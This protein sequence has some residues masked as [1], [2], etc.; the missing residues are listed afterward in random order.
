MSNNDGGHRCNQGVTLATRP[1]RNTATARLPPSSGQGPMAML[2]SHAPHGM[3]VW[4]IQRPRFVPHLFNLRS[5]TWLLFAVLGCGMSAVHAA[6][7]A[8]S[9]WWPVQRPPRVLIPTT[10]LET[11]GSG[12]A[13]DTSLPSGGLSAEHMLVQSAAGL[14]ARAVNESRSDEM[15]WI[16]VAS[17]SYE[18]WKEEL[19]ERLAL[20][21]E[22]PH[23]PWQVVERL[24][25]QGIVKG[26]VV[27]S[28]D[29]SQGQPYTERAEVDQSA[30]VATVMAGLQ[31]AVLVESRM[32]PQARQLGLKKLGDA[33]GKSLEWCF[34]TY[35]DRLYRR[36]LF[37]LDP[38]TAHNRALAVAH[39]GMVIYGVGDLLNEVL[40]WLEPPSAVAGWN[41]GNEDQHTLPVSRYGHFQ[42]ASNWALNLP[43]LSAA[44]ET[45]MPR[46]LASA[47]L[48]PTG[49]KRDG[50]AEHM[51]AFLMSDGDNL[52]WSLGNFAHSAH[53][54]QHP[55]R[56]RVPVGWTACPGHLRQMCPGVLDYLS[57]TQPAHT[58]FIEYGGGY[59]Y[60][61]VFASK[62]DNRLELLAR[63]AGRIG[64]HMEATGV[65]LLSF[66]CQDVDS[67]A[68]HDA[69][70]V[71]A[72]EIR[73]LAGMFA[74]Q[75]YPYDGGDGKIF[76]VGNPKGEAIPVVTPKYTVWQDAH[77]P[78]GGDPAKIAQLIN[79]QAAAASPDEPL[80]V[81]VAVNIWSRFPPHSQA[82]RSQDLVG[83]GSVEHCL[84][85]LDPSIRVVTPEALVH[86]L[87]RDRTTTRPA[88]PAADR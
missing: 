80:R 3:N 87:R 15:V 73:N 17:P 16:S 27:Y 48:E 52:Q 13:A 62:R 39:R 57:R 14:A 21:T 45:A 1:R 69:Y 33:R 64:I 32:E 50:T 29:E 77:W 31:D 84:G 86:Q 24:A 71:Y 25:R 2:K 28:L 75:Y 23:R 26:Y 85:S 51:V 74:L 11:F 9:R 88:L 8:A 54:W 20:D 44:A 37:T 35:R 70:Q 65:S 58:S 68:A 7:P 18:W 12:D 43:V 76:W 46:P 30:N 72:R 34:D 5:A 6:H 66:I 55:S 56:G 49:P 10:P 61:D 36:L 19:V 83:L 53:Y 41:C 47:M 79:Q 63:H 67:A 38:K 22:S 82:D 81:V 60:P 40:E 59:Y 42:T 4:C 78:R